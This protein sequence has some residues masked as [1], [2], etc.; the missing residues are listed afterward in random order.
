MN[1]PGSFRCDCHSGYEVAPTGDE[2]QG[3]DD[4]DDDDD[5]TVVLVVVA[6]AAVIHAF[7]G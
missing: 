3:D 5:M 2:C 7:V 4:D 1:T 6:A